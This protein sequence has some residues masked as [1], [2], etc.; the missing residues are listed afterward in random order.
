[1]S[2]QTVDGKAISAEERELYRECERVRK[3]I[4]SV[5]L[6]EDPQVACAAMCEHFLDMIVRHLKPEHIAHMFTKMQDEVDRRMK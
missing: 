3:S 2:I 1:M 4:L 6:Y 5:L